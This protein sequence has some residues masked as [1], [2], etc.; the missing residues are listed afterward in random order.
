MKRRT[1]V[2]V[3]S[4]TVLL[5]LFLVYAPVVPF[6]R[7]QLIYYPTAPSAC[8]PAGIACETGPHQEWLRSYGSFTYD[9]F[10]FGTAPYAG[11]VTF[12]KN[13]FTTVVV[14]NGTDVGEQM[15]YPSGAP[16]QPVSL[17][18][19]GKVL[20]LTNATPF[21][22]TVVA[23]NVTNHGVNEAA[24][25]RF[26]IVSLS[27]SNSLFPT[28]TSNTRIPSGRSVVLNFTSWAGPF[29]TAG[30]MVRVEVFG[31]ICYGSVCVP[32]ARFVIAP[33]VSVTLGAQ[34]NG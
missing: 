29:P 3:S 10:G 9:A 26:A 34:T 27:V 5:L 21:G 13:N 28:S 2:I 6:E 31:S 16:P 30:S 33:V 8:I 24:D 25:V 19:V 1:V 14:Y 18:S 12:S 20:V 4:L 23:V 32:Y 22:G 17:I 7:L 15:A 11:P